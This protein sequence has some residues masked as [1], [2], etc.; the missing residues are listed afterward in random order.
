MKKDIDDL[1]SE[2]NHYK[3]E[4]EMMVSEI[5]ELKKQIEWEWEFNS[6]Q[7]VQDTNLVI[8]SSKISGIIENMFEQG[9]LMEKFGVVGNL[10][11]QELEKKVLDL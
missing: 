3:L 2:W 8:S 4:T 5:F 11:K 10:S 7:E 6:H 9:E 1:T